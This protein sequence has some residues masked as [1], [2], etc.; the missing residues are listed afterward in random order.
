MTRKPTLTALIAALGLTL[1]AG[2]A[3]AQYPGYPHGG[4]GG[5]GP[6]HHHGYGPGYYGPAYRPA[7]PVYVPAPVVVAPPVVAAPPVGYY[8]PQSGFSLGV[9]RPGLSFGLNVLR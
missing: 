8:G 7:A 1:T 3:S 5:Y 2:A 9:N 4:Y 6:H